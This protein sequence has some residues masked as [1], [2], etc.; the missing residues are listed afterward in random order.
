[1]ITWAQAYLLIWVVSTNSGWRV[2]FVI[3][4]WCRCNGRITGGGSWLCPSCGSVKRGCPVCWPFDW[5]KRYSDDPNC[6]TCLS[7]AVHN[8]AIHRAP[9]SICEQMRFETA[10][11]RKCPNDHGTRQKCNSWYETACSNSKYMSKPE[12][13]VVLV[14]V[15]DPER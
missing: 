4:R 2:S 12:P 11:D 7:G 3:K 1:M 9:P 15:L 8:T 5:L 6:H 13:G 10:L 14:A